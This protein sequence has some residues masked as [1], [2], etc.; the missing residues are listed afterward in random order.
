MD[1]ITKVGQKGFSGSKYCQEVLIGIVDTINHVSLRNKNGVLLSLDI[2]KAFDSTSHSYLQMVYRFFNF[3]PNFIKWLNLIGTN[4][5]ACI[6][7]GNGTYSEFFDLERGNAQGDTTSPYILNLGF[8]ILILKLTFDLQIEGIVE[9]PTIPDNVPPP[10]RTVSTYTR[11]VSAYA[12]DAS[13]IV[14]CNY[15]NLLRV[16]NILEEFGNMSGLVCNVEKTVLLPIGNN[17]VIDDNI[18]TLG[19][20][21]A[22]KL[23]ILGLEID[24]NG[25]TNSNYRKIIDKIRNQISIWRPFNL[26]L[27]GRISIAKTMLYSQ[28]NYLGCFL[29]MQDDTMSVMED[30]IVSFVKGSINI[31]KKRVFLP[32]ENGGLGLFPIKDFVDAQKCTWIKRSTDYSEPWKI[33]IYVNNFGNLFNCKSRNINKAEYPIIHDICSSYERVMH[34]F[35]ATQ[36]NFQKSFIFEN[37]CFTVGLRSKEQLCR[38]HFNDE[39]FERISS[40]LYNLRYCDL[41]SE[42]NVFLTIEAIGRQLGI[43][44]TQLQFFNFR[45]A[46]SVAKVKYSKKDLDVQKS[47]HIE[48][49]LY[50]RKRGS[51]HL[52]KILLNIDEQGIPHNINKFSRNVDIVINGEQAKFLNGLWANNLFTSQEKTFFF[53][54]HNNTLGFNNAVAHF[55]NGHSPFCTFCDLA[56]SPEQNPETPLH[57]F[58][59]CQSVADLIETVFKRV[60]G[61]KNFTFSRREFFASFE[62]REL[63]HPMNKC[64]T[65]FSKLLIKYLWDCRTRSYLPSLEHCWENMCDRITAAGKT[66][67]KFG[68]MWTV[69]GQFTINMQADNP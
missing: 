46:C 29:P 32:V 48:T 45:N 38:R 40:K 56:R 58:F 10:P 21:V 15:N 24:K 55:V 49:F 28:I 67:R 20:T 12:D 42:Q 36:E 69:V 44:L 4:R 7:L 54:L 14:K 25:F 1:K 9:F 47:R 41:F 43:H 61:N 3:G 62:R 17:T 65:V 63:T 16:K 52:R 51:S 18:L 34:A 13:L 8:Q 37:G 66:N 59:E 39:T 50:Q 22:E 30:L 64:L 57:L 27:P 35:T 33:V 26:S 23:T 2:K 31:A 68:A 11:K 19:F 53:K 5:K 6:I 60:T